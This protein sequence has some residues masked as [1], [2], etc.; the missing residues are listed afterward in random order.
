MLGNLIVRLSKWSL[1]FAVCC[2]L[3]CA[4]GANASPVFVSFAPGQAVVGSFVLDTP[5]LGISNV[6]LSTSTSLF[7]GLSE[8]F[9]SGNFGCSGGPDV[10]LQLTGSLGDTLDIDLGLI[11]N[12]IS[13]TI[14][15]PPGLDSNIDVSIICGSSPCLAAFPQGGA[16]LGFFNVNVATPEPS[17]LLLLGTGLL[18]L[19]PLIRRRFARA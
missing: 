1:A 5:F 8:T 15:L 16:D 10:C 19:G 12:P 18:G 17:S 7:F 4:R 2:L 13:G 6:S 9:T 11:L 3:F 14:S